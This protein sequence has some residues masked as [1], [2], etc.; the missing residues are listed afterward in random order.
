MV[1]ALSACSGLKPFPTQT[2]YEFDTK[3]HVCGVYKITNA[4]TFQFAHVKDLPL[5]QCPAIFGFS[6]G[7]I[8]KVLDWSRDAVQ[9]AK[10]RC[11]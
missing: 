2:L 6:S 8:P 5:A 4:E 9:Y 3:D 1:L 10:T 7:D 11:N